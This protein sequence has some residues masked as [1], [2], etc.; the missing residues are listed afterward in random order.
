MRR[1]Q[2]FSLAL[3]LVLTFILGA[4]SSNEQKV[5]S[6]ENP[7][8]VETRIVEDAFGKVEIP[9]HP[10][11]VAAVYLEDYLSALDIK[12]V[13]QWYHPTWGIQEYLN[14]DVPKFD[15]TGS[16]EA[17]LE[18]KPDLIIVDGAV[19]SA[20]YEK[21]SKIAPTYRLKEEILQNPRDIVKTIADVLNVSEKADEVVKQYEER[22]TSLKTE[23]DASL[24]DETVAVLRLNVGD[25]TLALFGIE[26]RFTGNVYKETGLTP[27]PLVRDMKEFQ[28]VLSEEAIPNLDADHIIIFPSEGT[29]ESKE[30]QEAVQWLDS[31]LWKSVP[32]VKNGHVYI[33]NR[34]YWQSG[35]ITA[36]LLKYDDLEKWFVK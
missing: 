1:G 29:W 2:Y 10:Q 14:L 12:P 18:A 20:K 13:I 21:Y 6:K 23:L 33:A 11:R 31:T 5:E 16:I 15:V 22:V 36:N 19:D 35:A 9:A 27:H 32:A 28:E 30:N 4:C 7:S 8:S 24:G 17:L 34:T 3:L 25:K 26:N